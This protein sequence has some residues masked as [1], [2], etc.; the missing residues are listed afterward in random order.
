M[1]LTAWRKEIEKYQKQTKKF[2]IPRRPFQNLVR[3]PLLL[4]L[5][6]FPLLNHGSGS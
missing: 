3:A 6:N 2:M 4:L 5:S 1:Y